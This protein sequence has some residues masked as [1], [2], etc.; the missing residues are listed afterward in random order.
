MCGIGGGS[1]SC[2]GA[3]LIAWQP[4]IEKLPRVMP[5]PAV[6]LT[7]AQPLKGLTK[8]E[9]TKVPLTVAPLVPY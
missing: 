5:Q 3:L 6:T 9:Q 1:V 7:P 4:A 2:F 8:A